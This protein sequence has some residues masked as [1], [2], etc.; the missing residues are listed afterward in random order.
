MD[1]NN[2]AVYACPKG[3]AQMHFWMRLPDRTAVCDK[4]GLK[5]TVAQAD[6]CFTDRSGS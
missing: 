4:C 1:K 6:D 3:R 2:P 5:L